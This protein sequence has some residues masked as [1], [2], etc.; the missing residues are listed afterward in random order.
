MKANPLIGKR[1][2]ASSPEDNLSWGGHARG[3]GRG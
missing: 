2:R 3:R 1:A